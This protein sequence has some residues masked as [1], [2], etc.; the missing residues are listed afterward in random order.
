V[1]AVSVIKELS[2]R[3]ITCHVVSGDQPTVVSNIA[4]SVNIQPGKVASRQLPTDKQAYVQNFLPK[5]KHSGNGE[6]TLKEQN[7]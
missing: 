7:I 2:T 4:S 6:Y 5:S 3:G 1:K